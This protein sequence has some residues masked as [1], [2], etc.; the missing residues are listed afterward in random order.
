MFERYTTRAR[1]TIFVSRY[2]AA[3]LGANEI[4]PEHLLLG[5]TRE[6]H[7]LLRSLPG[8]DYIDQLRN[9]VLAITPSRDTNPSLDIPLSMAAKRTLLYA[10]EEA[11]ALGHSNIGTEHL[12]LGILREPDSEIGKLCQKYGAELSKARQLLLTSELAPQTRPNV[13]AV[14]HRDPDGCIVF[15][16]ANSGERVGIAGLNGLQKVPREGEFVLLDDY[17]GKPS[18]F[19]VVEVVYH[20][21]REPA[22]APASAHELCSI[23]IRVLQIAPRANSD[24]D[25]T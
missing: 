1:R 6:S 7:H 25:S 13:H 15:V 20:F 10:A 16:E 9:E 23:S 12:F 22:H 21:H 5:L 4:H 2:E 11:D 19:R 18:R 17:H 14:T 3:Q 8:L 24:V